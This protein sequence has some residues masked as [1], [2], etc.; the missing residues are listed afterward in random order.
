MNKT[1]SGLDYGHGQTNVDKE[2]GIRYGVISANTPFNCSEEFYEHAE[3][4]SYKAAVEEQKAKIKAFLSDEL[5]VRDRLIDSMVSDVW[6]AVEQ[7]FNDNYDTCD[8]PSRRY[9]K[10]G[11]IIETCLDNDLIVIKSPYYTH[12]Q[13]CSPCVPGAG[14]L[15]S[16][17]VDGPKT[18]CLG[19]DWFE[20]A[21]APYPVYTVGDPNCS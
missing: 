9:E 11:Y 13:F 8:N 20:D 18:Y 5:Y 17:C 3:D 7:Y 1:Y 21:T 15:D 2:N 12:A 4:L 19:P 16:P 14:N 6:D 10:D